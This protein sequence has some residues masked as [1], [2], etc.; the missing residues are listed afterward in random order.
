MRY[1]LV[2]WLYP[3]RLSP[4]DPSTSLLV[5]V[6]MR[7]KALELVILTWCSVAL[8]PRRALH[9]FSLLSAECDVW[10]ARYAAVKVS[11]LQRKFENSLSASKHS[12][13]PG[14]VLPSRPDT[15]IY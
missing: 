5:Y 15:P 6:S 2:P 13:S 8:F 14:S 3:R 7:T 4:Q 1:S 10:F 12:V 9:E 11:P